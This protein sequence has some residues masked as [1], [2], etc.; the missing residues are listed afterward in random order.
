ML[1]TGPCH[2][3]K[4]DPRGSAICSLLAVSSWSS[5]NASLSWASSRSLMVRW[6][7]N[8]DPLGSLGEDW[9]T[10]YPLW[11]CAWAMDG[12][13][14]LEATYS[15]TC[16]GVGGQ[17]QILMGPSCQ[18]MAAVKRHI[19]AIISETDQNARTILVCESHRIPSRCA[20]PITMHCLTMSS[21]WKELG[22]KGVPSSW[23]TARILMQF[24]ILGLS[25]RVRA[26]ASKVVT[27]DMVDII[28]WGR[29]DKSVDVG[30]RLGQRCDSQRTMLWLITAM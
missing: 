28:K 2:W 14:P 19:L 17:I 9:E 29:M 5:S 10:T 15:H 24:T 26:P 11:I 20:W 7:C 3:L 30:L 23:M 18:T 13:L 27:V 25:P 12:C 4:G 21:C 22:W 16:E 8:W 6:S 1:P